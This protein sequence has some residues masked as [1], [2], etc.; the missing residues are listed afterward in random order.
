MFAQR[1]KQWSNL[2]FGFWNLDFGLRRA[3]LGMLGA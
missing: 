2:D 1:F 3:P